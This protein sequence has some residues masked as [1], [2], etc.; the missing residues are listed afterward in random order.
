MSS[1]VKKEWIPSF[2]GLRFLM[3]LLLIF[4]H[5]D[6]YQSLAVPQFDAVMRY[7]TEGAVCV[8]FFFILS[9]FVIQYSYGDKIIYKRISPLRFILYR[10]AHLWPIH[11]LMI[12]ICGITYLRSVNFFYTN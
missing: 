5:F 3:V 12:L 10:L 4:H 7:L 6:M 9:G 1:A 2:G 8:S 11:A